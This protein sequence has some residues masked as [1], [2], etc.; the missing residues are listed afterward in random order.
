MKA[1]EFIRARKKVWRRG[2]GDEKTDE[3]MQQAYDMLS[4]LPWS[5]NIH[6]FDHA[7]PLDQLATYASHEWLGTTHENQILD[8]LRHDLLLNGSRIEV[9]GMAFFTTIRQAYERCDAGMYEES[10]HFA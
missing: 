7:E 5:G 3:V 10:R 1:E 4:C 2:S 6:G 8:L 9:P